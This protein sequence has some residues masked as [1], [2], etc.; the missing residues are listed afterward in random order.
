LLLAD[1]CFSNS[2]IHLRELANYAI[3]QCLHH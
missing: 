1:A 3:F 2:S